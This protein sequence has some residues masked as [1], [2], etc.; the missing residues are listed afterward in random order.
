M[1]FLDNL[2]GKKDKPAGNR[3]QRRQ[4][5]RIARLAGKPRQAGYGKLKEVDAPYHWH[6]RVIKAMKFNKAVVTALVDTKRF[7]RFLEHAVKVS[8]PRPNRATRRWKRAR[9]EYRAA[10]ARMAAASVT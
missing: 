5:A 1:S 2:L 8:R 6:R 4:M 3:A 10:L 7:D 9:K